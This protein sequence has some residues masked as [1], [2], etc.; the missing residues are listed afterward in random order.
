MIKVA[1]LNIKS[2]GPA[3]P[4]GSAGAQG[5]A[6]KF[7]ESRDRPDESVAAHPNSSGCIQRP[8]PPNWTTLLHKEAGTPIHTPH[9]PTSGKHGE[10]EWLSI[11]KAKFW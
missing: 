9:Y 2:L 1:G 6:S 10:G 7:K 4:K 11:E 8:Q 3:L 5:A